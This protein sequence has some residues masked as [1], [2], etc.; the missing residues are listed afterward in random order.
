MSSHFVSAKVPRLERVVERMGPFGS[1][2][3]AVMVVVWLVAWSL[4]DEALL[5]ALYGLHIAVLMALA[6]CVAVL[7]R[8]ARAW[9][10]GEAER[11]RMEQSLRMSEARLAGI[12]SGAAEAI[13]SIDGS[14][15][16]T[17]FN[18]GAERIFGYS[19]Q[20]ALG[21]SLDVLLPERFQQVHRQHVQR[22]AAGARMS[23]S[24]AERRPILGRRKSGEEFPA[25]A[26]ISKVDTDGLHLLTVM[27]RDISVRKRAE[28]VLRNSEARFRT[29]FEDAPIGMALVGLDGRFLH[30]NG[31]LGTI[32][33][34]S[35]K[36]LVART[37]QEITWP[38]DLEVDLAHVQRLLQGEIESYQLEKRYLHKQGHL[39]SVLLTASLVR[40]S[41]GAPLHFVSQLQDISERKQLEQA[42]RFLAEAGPQLA[43]SLDPR[44][45]L[46]TVARLAVPALAEWCIVEQVDAEGRIRSLEG[47]A[48]ST[49][50]SRQLDAFLA[51]QPRDVSRR[52]GIVMGVLQTGRPALFPEVPE[53]VLEAIAR[54]EE[55]MTLLRRLAPRSIIVVPLRARGHILGVV[56]L[57]N[58][59]P[60]RRFGARDLAL[61]EELASRAALA[62][63]NACLH[64]KSEQA[65]R[66]RDEVLRVVAHDLRTPLN[67]I[68]L[69][70]TTLLKR[71]PEQRA[72]DTRPLESIRKAVERAHRLIQDLLDVAK[73]EAGHLS[74]E[75]APVETAALVREALELHRALAEEKSLRLTAAVPEDAPP[76]L[77]DHDRVLQILSNLIG[78]ALKFTPAGGQ[79]SVRVAAEGDMLRFSVRDTGAGIASGDLPHLFEAFWQARAGRKDGAGLGLAIVKGLVDAHGGRL[80][81]ESSPGLGSTFSFTL[82]AAPRVESQL[83]HH[84]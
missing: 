61:A 1:G 18:E 36:E 62:I 19:A 53:G 80:W 12:V 24:M 51:A 60:E 64:E 6:I 58:S 3:A 40:D 7:T 78:N 69:S 26:S 28:E 9:T 70:A 17:V 13:I 46:G 68:S 10:R 74:V 84:A 30:V 44:A 34:Y 79:V 22:F 21:Q 32:L 54:N 73:M 14:Q 56:V 67:V 39:V 71:P 20:E 37:F 48:A 76:L 55:H 57:C 16:I 33:G 25:E 38:E 43:G 47:A 31:A 59:E 11:Q 82:P 63:D 75:C 41:Q 77:A 2:L 29:S 5:H 50:K 81:V 52:G 23:R 4:G 45:T 49:E 66:L 42:L 83:T 35:P 65:T 15:R 27:L 72:T 8:H